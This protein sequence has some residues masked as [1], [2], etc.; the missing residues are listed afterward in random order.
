MSS[1]INPIYY[2]VN[3]ELNSAV[4]SLRTG[5][6]AYDGK[7]IAIGG[8]YYQYQLVRSTDASEYF[9]SDSS[10]AFAT[11]K[12]ALIDYEYFI[13]VENADSTSF[14]CTGR[15]YYNKLV[16]RA[17]SS[18]LQITVNFTSSA[19]KLAGQPYCM[20]TFPFGGYIRYWNIGIDP[21]ISKELALNLASAISEDLGSYVVDIQLLPFCPVQD[22]IR[23]SSPHGGQQ[24]VYIGQDMIIN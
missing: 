10:A 7:V 16:L 18:S 23:N 3:D 6:Q 5:I 11:I 12:N 17:L 13:N 2:D 24:V 14:S 8:D 20:A 4:S 1:V 15:R 22:R 9:I 21:Y 19:N